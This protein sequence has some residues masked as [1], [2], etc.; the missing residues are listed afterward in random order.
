M[1]ILSLASF[2]AGFIVCFYLLPYQVRRVSHYK[3]AVFCLS[4]LAPFGGVSR[5]AAVHLY[6]SL[7][8]HALY[9]FPNCPDCGYPFEPAWG[10]KCKEQA[11]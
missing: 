8:S 4:Q 9:P 11:E 1:I 6:R 10:C 5:K 3:D 2:L 7:D